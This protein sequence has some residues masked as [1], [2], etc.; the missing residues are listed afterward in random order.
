MAKF[1]EY[2]P[3][4]SFVHRMNPVAK[5]ACALLI[6]VACFCTSNVV[7]LLCVL[8][9][10]FVL[11]RACGM[12]R[13]ALGLARAVCVF[14]VVLAAIALLTT[15]AG[16]PLLALPWG[17]IGTGSL[18]AAVVIIVRLVACAIPLFLVMYVTKL[19]DIANACCKIL[20]V[21]YKYAFTFTSA[22]HFI[23]VFMNDMAGIM[24][25]QT[26]RGV[27]FDGGMLARLKLMVPLCVPLL[28]SSVRKTSSAAIAAEVR[29]FNLRT[30]QSGFKE[31]PFAARDVAAMLICAV[32]LV[33]SITTHILL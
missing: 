24:E 31:Y 30:R 12:T 7:F 4:T 27:E 6:S 19:T 11:A 28:V 14:S 26:A 17:F 21:P 1:L 10:D 9:A 18:L 25:A 16:T 15:P 2:V 3:G 33:A 32:I 20:H 8:A 5:L 13:Q 23:P 22:V 29:G